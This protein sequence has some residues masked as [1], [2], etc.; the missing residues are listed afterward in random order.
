MKANKVPCRSSSFTTSSAESLLRSADVLSTS[1]GNHDAVGYVLHRMQHHSRALNYNQ[2]NDFRP[3][4]TITTR[5]GD[6]EEDPSQ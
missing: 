6:V 1:E 3:E 2:S 4:T 5:G